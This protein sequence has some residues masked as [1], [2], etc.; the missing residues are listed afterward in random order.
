ML[1]AGW[2]K[3]LVDTNVSRPGRFHDLA[4]ADIV[5]IS[6]MIVQQE[7]AAP[8]HRALPR[9]AGVKVVA[10]GPAIQRATRIGS[11]RSTTWC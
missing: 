8:A 6:G 10:G 9:R 7:S 2:K 4:W 5:L 3:R 11:R 1:P